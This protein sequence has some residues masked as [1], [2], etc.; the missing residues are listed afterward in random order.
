[1][2]ITTLSNVA[3]TD[4]FQT[5][6]NATNTLATNLRDSIVTAN[7]T[8]GTTTGNAV[9]LGN[10]GAT[11]LFANSG[12]RGGNN[13]TSGTL[14][15]SS[16]AVFSG[17]ANV[18]GAANF[19]GV[20]NA[21][22][23]V[24]AGDSVF[25]STVN[26]AALNIT[27]PATFTGALTTTTNT[28]TIGTAA[29]FVANG[30][31]GVGTATPGSKL[32]V[33]GSV[34]ATDATLTTNTLTIGNGSY[35]VS[36]GNVG[37]GTA[38]PGSKL[39]VVGTEVRLQT[40]D[41]FYSIANTTGGRYGYLRG[42]A[43]GIQ[44]VSEPAAANIIYLQTTNSPDISIFANGNVGIGTGT[45]APGVK[46]QVNGAFTANGIIRG[47][48]VGGGEGGQIELNTSDNSG[49]GLFI[50]VVSG[51]TARVFSNRN[52]STIQ[53]GQVSGTGGSISF[54]TEGATRAAITSTGLFQFNSGY[55][56]A[57]TA[58]GCRAWINFDGTAAFIG[59]G[60]GSGGVTSVTDNGTG[61]YTIN[62][63]FTFPDTF[64]AFAGSVKIT[65]FV[66]GALQLQSGI[67]N[68]TT[69]SL[70][71]ETLNNAGTRTDAASVDVVVFR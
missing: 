11:T 38:S 3:T 31:L 50:D 39:Q 24:V 2:A 53:I 42:L 71:I 51:N 45:S 17:T 25:S 13:S 5:W 44:L 55:G 16:N 48:A 18:A 9:V 46:L 34:S 33:A 1:M 57:A 61:T 56:S 23:L 65:D 29:F 58:Y 43:S 8:L 7:S 27:G 66:T 70:A 60:R 19:A 35:F 63:S 32:T 62:F 52:S 15:I 10:L 41:A 21:A 69:S 36:N 64:Y 68:K 22:S 47:E 4:T 20:V 67:I 30:N 26:A 54:V 40:T 37:I 14:T 59:S 28:T 6:L 12:I 49:T